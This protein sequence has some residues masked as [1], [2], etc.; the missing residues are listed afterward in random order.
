MT[1]KTALRAALVLA[2][3]ASVQPAQ[4][5]DT[6]F[7]TLRSQYVS[8]TEQRGDAVQRALGTVEALLKADPADAVAMAYKGSLLTMA[9]GDAMMPWNKL[10]YVNVGLELMDDAVARSGRAKAH[11][12]DA[13]VE[14]LMVAGFTFSRLPSM[15][16]REPHARKMIASL[17]AHPG[18]GTLEPKLQAQALA[19]AAAFATKDGKAP[20]AQ[21]L[22]GR[23]SAADAPTA[24]KVYDDR[25]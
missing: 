24:R 22:L 19:I 17:I 16:K 14:I 21:A 3:L 9:G 10:K 7:M 15:F 12:I 5:K 8:A 25:T 20:E 1:L 23:A 11:D 4:A 2:V 18:F 6:A 13:Q